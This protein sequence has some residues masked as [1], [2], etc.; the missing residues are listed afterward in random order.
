MASALQDPNGQPL[1]RQLPRAKNK[2]PRTKNPALFSV[3][4][5]AHHMLGHLAAV[6]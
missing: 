2:E 4:L 5:A 6:Y 1:S 3:L